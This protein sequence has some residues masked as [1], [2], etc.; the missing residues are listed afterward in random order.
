MALISVPVAFGTVVLADKIIGLI[1]PPAEF[2]PAASV[3][4]ILVGSVA[5]GHL[6][7]VI[8]TLLVASNR[9]KAFMVASLNIAVIA[10]VANLTFVPPYGP[11]AVACIVAG[12]D[13]ALFIGM[14]VYLKRTDFSFS[15]LPLYVKPVLSAGSMAATLL[16]LPPLPVLLSV[17][18]GAVVYVVMIILVKGLGQQ[19]REVI[20]GVL[21]KLN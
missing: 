11:I 20:Q 2:A 21:R 15:V 14:Y 8:G 16:L 7:S 4:A 17:L 13:L 18:L 10:T 19:E 12:A 3:L 1:F 6:N 5:F 9:Q